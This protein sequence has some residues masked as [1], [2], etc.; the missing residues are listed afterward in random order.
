MNSPSNPLSIVFFG[1]S[2]AGK[3]TQ[4]DMLE[5]YLREHDSSRGVA[6]PDMGNLTRAFVKTVSPLAKKVGEVIN[7]GGL[8][9][10]FMPIYLLTDDMNKHFTGDEHVIFDGVAR[11]PTQSHAIDDMMRFWGRTNLHGISLVVSET[12]AHERLHGRGRSDDLDESVIKSRFQWYR[13]NVVPSI[14]ALEERGWSIHEID[15]ELDPETIH[16]AILEALNIA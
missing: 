11:R 7:A 9:P 14:K 8:M 12:T 1:I 2:G 4:A 3:G 5:K 16:R 6:H 10:S 13:E 15:A